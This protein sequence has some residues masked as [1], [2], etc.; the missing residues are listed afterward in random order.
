MI[1]SNINNMLPAALRKAAKTAEEAGKKSL[2]RAGLKY[3]QNVSDKDPKPPIRWG[4]LR[5][6][7]FVY[8]GRRKVT[9]N[10]VPSSIQEGEFVATVGMS[11]NYASIQDN[12]LTPAGS[13]QLGAR[14]R[15]ASGVSGGFF[16]E[17]NTKFYQREYRQIIADAIKE[18]L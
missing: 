2:G 12:N 17:K 8:V 14:S 6:S 5:G 3:L 9:G 1:D 16:T 10:S 18:D 7:G 15:R 13:W 4:Y 11:A